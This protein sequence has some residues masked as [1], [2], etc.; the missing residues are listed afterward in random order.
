MFE[1]SEIRPMIAGQ[2]APPMIDITRSEDPRLVNR[3]RFL[4]L[5]AKIV[6]NMIEWKKPIRTMA[7]TETAPE[8]ATE[9]AAQASGPPANRA[10][11]CGAERRIGVPEPAKRPH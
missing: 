6:G 3:P 8:L 11:T 10:A 7:K 4:M 9:T 5:R 1:R 2:I